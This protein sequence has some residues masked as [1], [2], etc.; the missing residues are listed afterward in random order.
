MLVH[1]RVT[2]FAGEIQFHGHMDLG[3]SLISS[4]YK[5]LWSD[6]VEGLQ[7]MSFTC[8]LLHVQCSQRW[9]FLRVIKSQPEGTFTHIYN[10]THTYT[11]IYI[12]IYILCFSSGSRL[13]SLYCVLLLGRLV[14]LDSHHGLLAGDRTRIHVLFSR[15]LRTLANPVD[16]V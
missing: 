4:M 14:D 10:H 15:S 1:Q 7:P 13:W 9:C 11:Y 16:T 2:M 8:W 5:S 12:H 3:G 6:H